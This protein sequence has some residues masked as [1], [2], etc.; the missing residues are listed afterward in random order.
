MKRMNI[1]AS[2]A[3]VTTIS[4]AAV[5]APQWTTS[6]D[7][8]LTL[9][10]FGDDVHI[11]GVNLSPNPAGCSNTSMA[12]VRYSLSAASKEALAMVLTSALLANR[13]VKLRLDDTFCQ[14]GVPAV[15]GVQIQ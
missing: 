1:L 8:I 12:K 6:W 4:A 10:S 15:I 11:Y 14:D 13:E 7:R 3:L 9:E 5:A 2:L